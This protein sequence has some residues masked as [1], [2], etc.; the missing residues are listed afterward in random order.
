MT[1]RNSNDPNCLFKNDALLHVR[2]VLKQLTSE[3]ERYKYTSSAGSPKRNGATRRRLRVPLA[4]AILSEQIYYSESGNKRK[5]NML[6]QFQNFKQLCRKEDTF[7]RHVGS[8]L[9]NRVA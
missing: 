3:G 9:P 6:C 5:Q 1:V 2:H 7:W 8:S 4:P